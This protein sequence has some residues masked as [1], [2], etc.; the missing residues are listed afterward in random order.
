MKLTDWLF[1]QR[2]TAEARASLY[3]D[4]LQEEREEKESALRNCAR[5]VVQLEA[6]DQTIAALRAQLAA[7]QPAQASITRLREELDKQKRVNNELSNQLLDATGHNG[8]P[9]TPEQ[10]DKLGLTGV[11]KP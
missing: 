11:V 4:W 2:R 6:K 5:L 8:K 3:A 9:L 7:R 10:R 1:T